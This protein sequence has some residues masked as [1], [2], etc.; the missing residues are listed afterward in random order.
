MK[1]DRK[2]WH[3]NVFPGVKV[4]AQLELC[5]ANIRC[6][7]SWLHTSAAWCVCIL[8]TVSY[9]TT[10]GPAMT[11]GKELPLLHLHCARAPLLGTDHNHWEQSERHIWAPLQKEPAPFLPF[12][13]LVFRSRPLQQ[14]TTALQQ[15]PPP[16]AVLLP[17]LQ[18][19]MC[20]YL[21]QICPCVPVINRRK[22]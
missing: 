8:Y 12:S 18:T 21:A 19:Q 13:P 14:K 7:S 10:S 20:I 15:A 5:G 4:R 17:L 6:A 3:S 16:S 11:S 22:L 2:H 9:I 1:M